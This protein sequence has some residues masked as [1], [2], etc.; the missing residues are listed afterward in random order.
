[1]SEVQTAQRQTC[2]AII[3]MSSVRSLAK[4]FHET[5]CSVHLRLPADS[6]QDLDIYKYLIGRLFV[7]HGSF[8][9]ETIWNCMK[10]LLGFRSL[11][12]VFMVYA[13]PEKHKTVS[14]NSNQWGKNKPARMT[15]W[16]GKVCSL[17]KSNSLLNRQLSPCHRKDPLVFKVGESRQMPQQFRWVN[18]DR[19]HADVTLKERKSIGTRDVPLWK[20]HRRYLSVVF[21]VFLSSMPNKRLIWQ[22]IQDQMLSPRRRRSEW[23]WTACCAQWTNHWWMFRSGEET[24]SNICSKN[25]KSIS[26]SEWN[27][28]VDTVF[29]KFDFEILWFWNLE[30]CSGP[31]LLEF[32]RA[33]PDG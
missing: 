2:N 27:I 21:C 6:P 4:I 22:W 8:H 16:A 7:A 9:Q 1:M 30:G 32:S 3:T 33:S 15:I 29:R 25:N 11:P 31:W 10:T 24:I 20:C 12:F 28:P 23:R 14:P 13:K 18:Y 17:W 5:H 26:W 19:V